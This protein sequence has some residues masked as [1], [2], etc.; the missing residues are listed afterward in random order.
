MQWT[1]LMGIRNA[2]KTFLFFIILYSL[3]CDFYYLLL[4]NL[5]NLLAF[6]FR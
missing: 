1:V 3:M 2:S 4:D 6:G 5:Y